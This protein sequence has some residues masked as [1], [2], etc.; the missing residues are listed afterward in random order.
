M[1][2]SKL[3][4][5]EPMQRA[6]DK[7]GYETATPIQSSAIPVVLSGADLIGCAQTGTGKTAAFTLPMLHHLYETGK[8]LPKP[9]EVPQREKSYKKSKYGRQ[10]RRPNAD[11]RPLRALVL[12]PT[13]ELAAQIEESFRRYGKFTGL[14]SALV[15]GGVKQGPQ[16]N[17]IRRGVD[18]LIATPGRLLDL[19]G[20]GFID[21]SQIELLIFDEADQMLDMGFVPD[22]TKIVAQVPSD[23][24]TLMFSATM[25]DEIRKLA[26]K[27]LKNPESIDV[28]PA[29]DTEKR[30][31]QS[32]HLV[33]KGRKQEFLAHYLQTTDRSRTLV[34]S[35]TKHG[36]DKIVKKLIK[37][38]V[39]AAAIHGDKS[40]GARNRA[41]Q[42]FKGENPPVLVATDIAARGLDIRDVTHVVNYDLPDA[43]ET[44]VHRIGRTGRAGATGTAVS[45][46]S[47][48]EAKLLKQIERLI[49]EAIEIEPAVEGFEPTER[50]VMPA[51][52]KSGRR[53]RPQ[54]G[55]RGPGK[56][57]DEGDRENP[58]SRKPRAEGE[59]DRPRSR[60]PKLE[61]DKER[62]RS[63]KP[64][65][66]GESEK[67]PRARKPRTEGERENARPRK[68]KKPS[69]LN[70]LGGQRSTEESNASYESHDS[71]RSNTSGKKRVSGGKGPKKSKRKPKS[72]GNKKKSYGE[73]STTENGNSKNSSRPGKPKPKKSPAKKKKRREKRI[74]AK[75]NG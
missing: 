68:P 70:R 35:R 39:H 48:A 20:Q 43:A 23:R 3:G 16:V 56:P 54:R 8:S 26:K 33:D 69:K 57:R 1:E 10:R 25:P 24:Q 38:G 46:C 36:A 2:F 37:S 65:R 63:R 12:S 51:D 15:F 52:K 59:R 7:L 64:K 9:T 58:R 34:F 45:F 5:A 18:A 27:W 47:A 53:R 11:N 55:S 31:K 29:T 22:L 17:A 49:K 19:M 75:T 41:I 72:F 62:P 32:V 14:R 28:T 73:R 30:I 44:Y 21:L 6:V 42:K 67:Q 4:L 74:A 40:Q 66:E 50:F 61:G 13:R 60:K 71:G